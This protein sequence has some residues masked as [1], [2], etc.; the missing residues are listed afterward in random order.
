MGWNQ[1]HKAAESPLLEDV[2]EGAYC[3]FV[4]SYALPVGDGTVATSTYGNEFAAMASHGN[5]AASQFHPER[6][7]AIGATI[8]RNFLKQ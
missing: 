8:L 3:Y 7:G 6:S 4:H 5:F 1:L 2:P